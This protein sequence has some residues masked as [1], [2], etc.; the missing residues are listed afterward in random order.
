MPTRFLAVMI[1]SAVALA[2]ACRPDDVGV[3]GLEAALA[4]RP[5]QIAFGN[6]SVGRER[7]AS[8][9]LTNMGQVPLHLQFAIE[10]VETLIGRYDP[11]TEQTPDIDL[12]DL[13][14]KRS[15][16]RRHARILQSES[17]YSLIEEVGALIDMPARHLF[18]REIPEFAVCTSRGVRFECVHVCASNSE[19]GDLHVAVNRDEHVGWA[20][21]PM[22]D[23][24]RVPAAV[25]RAVHGVEAVQELTHQIHD[26]VMLEP[27]ALERESA[28]EPPQVAA[29]NILKRQVGLAFD[30]AVTQ[31]VHD[32]RMRDVTREPRLFGEHLLCVGLVCD[33]WQ[34]S[35]EDHDAWLTGRTRF[36]RT[37]HFRHAPNC[38]TVDERVVAERRVGRR[39]RW[40]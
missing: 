30:F 25:G 35:L 37:K 28:V 5:E 29:R 6:T 22:H 8:V 24:K 16:S 33:V 7:T 17:G 12:T 26:E 3:R 34:H 32:V 20:D 1:M 2:G 18:G 40:R 31:D 39:R 36:E 14:L 9:M 10:G 38:N 13:D 19:V 21:I 15:V 4:V 23:S 11:V 27:F